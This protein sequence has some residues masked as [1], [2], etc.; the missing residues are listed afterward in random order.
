MHDIYCK[1]HTNFKGKEKRM[2]IAGRISR[3]RVANRPT[4]QTTLG[5]KIENLDIIVNKREKSV[6][7]LMEGKMEATAEK[8][9]SMVMGNVFS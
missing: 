7:Y 1:K 6:Q 3:C 5:A 9:E 4:S 8:F 2:H